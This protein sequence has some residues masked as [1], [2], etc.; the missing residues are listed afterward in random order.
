MYKKDERKMF[1]IA[2]SSTR[3]ENMVVSWSEYRMKL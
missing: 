1:F 2:E 3:I